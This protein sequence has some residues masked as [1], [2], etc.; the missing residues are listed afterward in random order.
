MGHATL[1]NV[2]IAYGLPPFKGPEAEKWEKAVENLELVTGG[3]VVGPDSPKK[4][5]VC[6]TCRFAH[7]IFSVKEPDRGVWTGTSSNFTSLPKPLSD[8]VKSFPVPAKA[9]QRKPVTFN[10][11][12]N[13]KLEPLYDGLDYVSIAPIGQIKGDVNKWIEDQQLR[14]E[15]SSQTHES[16]LNGAKREILIWESD[17][18]LVLIRYEHSDGTSWVS[19]TFYK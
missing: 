15:F 11:S 10:Q 2:P 6:T 8:R 19:A 5:V 14:C 4:Q 16:S 17:Q 3:C 1:K 9:M 13:D 12:L 18:L 7:S